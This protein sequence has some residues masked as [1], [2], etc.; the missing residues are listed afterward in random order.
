MGD[1]HGELRAPPGSTVSGGDSYLATFD[2][3]EHYLH[4][5]VVGPRSP[6]NAQRF[7]RETHAACMRSARSAVLLEMS[8]TGPSLDAAAIFKVISGAA[9]EGMG[10][11]KI[12]YVDPAALDPGRPVFATNVAANR[13]VNVRLFGDAEAASRWLAEP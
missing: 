5:R 2:V 1:A 7:L 9:T 3:H 4:A 10:L 13:G 6:E 8:F 11:R 12:A